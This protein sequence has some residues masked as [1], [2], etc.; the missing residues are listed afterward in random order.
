MVVSIVYI[1]AAARN[2]WSGLPDFL[3][4]YKK[5]QA[6][7]LNVSQEKKQAGQELINSAPFATH[8]IIVFSP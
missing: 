5:K 3:A 1:Y 6:S 8:F 4:S 2:H 7:K